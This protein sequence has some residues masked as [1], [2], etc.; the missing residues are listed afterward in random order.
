MVYFY[1]YL[2]FIS[3]PLLE[4][5]SFPYKALTQFVKFIPYFM[6]CVPTV[7]L[8]YFHYIFN[9]CCWYR[10]ILFTF[11]CSSYIGKSCWAFLLVWLICWT[12]LLDFKCKWSYH[13]QTIIIFFPLVS[14]RITRTMISVIYT[15]HM[16]LACDFRSSASDLSTKYVICCRIFAYR[17]SE[18]TKFS[19][20]NKCHHFSPCILKLFCFPPV[21]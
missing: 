20:S 6:A 17:L 9:D 21:N 19:I 5:N 10:G 8:S 11:I 4:F 13:E 16:L 3:R 12:I 7:T 1:I 18:V 2:G 14:A 15:K